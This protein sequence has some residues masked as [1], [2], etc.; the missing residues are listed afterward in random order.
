MVTNV[1]NTKNTLKL[2]WVGMHLL[3]KN[4]RDYCTILSFG[5]NLKWKAYSHSEILLVVTMAKTVTRKCKIITS[6]RPVTASF[7]VKILIC[8]KNTTNLRRAKLHR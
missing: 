3:Q 1:H 8:L 2:T 6:E 4:V 7:H 5:R